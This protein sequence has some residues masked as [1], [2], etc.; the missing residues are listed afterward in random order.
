M[1]F[2]LV[3]TVIASVTIGA[4][5]SVVRD[6]G[7]V[8]VSLRDIAES[9][10]IPLSAVTLFRFVCA[11]VALYTMLCV[12]CDHEG[13]ALHYRGAQVHLRRHSRWTTFTLWCFT[14]LFFYFTLAAYCSGAA[15]VGRDDIVPSCVVIATLVLFEVSYPM[16]VLVTAIVTFVLIPVAYR[17]HHPIGR[18]F[19]WRP[20]M[21]HNGNVLMMQLAMLSAPPPVTLAHLLYAV[22]FGCCYTIFAWCW[23]WRTRVFYYFFLDYHR[24]YAVV[25]YLGL[26]ATLAMLYGF[27]Y[28]IAVIARHESSRWW[29]YPCIMLITLCIM[30]FREPTAPHNPLRGALGLVRKPDRLKPGAFPP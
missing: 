17:R 13:L 23:F 3:A 11:G 2:T 28:L 4:V 5:L 27:G 20:L 6:G 9:D 25:A 19:G 8:A 12:Y 10:V 24:P 18:M 22:L 30:R 29:T 26:L 1:G 21:L 16:S 7:V 15:F 14:L